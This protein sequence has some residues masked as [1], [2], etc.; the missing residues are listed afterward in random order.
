MKNCLLSAVLLI[1]LLFTGCKPAQV[2][3]G[4]TVDVHDTHHVLRQTD[5]VMLYVRDSVVVYVGDTVTVNRWHTRYRDHYRTVTD[6]LIRHDSIAV[7]KPVPVYKTLTGWQNFQVW[8]GRL[9]LVTVL[10]GLLVRIV[11]RY[12]KPF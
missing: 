1:S 12:L 4:S 11:K 3:G 7:E 9:L 8:C 5:S 10:G 6:T 2:M